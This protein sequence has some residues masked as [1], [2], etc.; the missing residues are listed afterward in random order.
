MIL[1]AGLKGITEGYD[2][3]DEAPASLFDG[4][5]PTAGAVELPQS[6]AEAIDAMEGSELVQDALG[7]HIFEWFLRN[8][9]AEWAEYKSQV[10][11]FEL[12]RYLPAW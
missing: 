2:L 9:R 6:L 5:E 8:K 10:S 11:A 4:Q 7:E 12:E 1:A 3:P